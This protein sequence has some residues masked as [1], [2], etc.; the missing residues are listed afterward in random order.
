MRSVRDNMEVKLKGIPSA[1]L[2]KRGLAYDT[3]FALA[4][5][6]YSTKFLPRENETG[7]MGTFETAFTVPDLAAEKNWLPIRSV[8][9]SNQ[10][11]AQRRHCQRRA[12]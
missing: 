10:V 8:V 12:G 9:L 11:E 1:E 2:A 4:P 7:R 3:G 6:A 5:G